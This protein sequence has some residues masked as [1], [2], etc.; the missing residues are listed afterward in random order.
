MINKYYEYLNVWYSEI[1][2]PTHS[3]LIIKEYVSILVISLKFSQ[4]LLWH[5]YT[6][7]WAD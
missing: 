4:I 3:E 1:I 7:Q 5:K 2:L 6:N